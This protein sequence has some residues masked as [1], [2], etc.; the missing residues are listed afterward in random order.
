MRKV[1]SF[2]TSQSNNVDMFQLLHC[3]ACTRNNVREMMHDS[4]S[5][6]L[7][8][9][10]RITWWGW[11]SVR[12]LV[13]YLSLCSLQHSALHPIYVRTRT[14]PDLRLRTRL[15]VVT[16]TVPSLQAVVCYVLHLD[17]CAVASVGQG[18]RSSTMRYHPC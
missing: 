5:S 17:C 16:S 4:G 13:V 2:S 3:P 18:S 15:I 7:Q 8:A 10:I 11:R 1:G 9:I 6:R 12:S 14:W